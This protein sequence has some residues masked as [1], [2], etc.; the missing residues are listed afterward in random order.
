[1][2]ILYILLNDKIEIEEEN[3]E[4]FNKQFKKR[5]YRRYTIKYQ[6]KRF[7]FL[8]NQKQI[9]I[10]QYTDSGCG[11]HIWI[12]YELIGN[13][14]INDIYMATKK[15]AENITNAIKKTIFNVEGI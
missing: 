1:M 12:K 6:D 10:Q 13:C 2:N 3:I 14:G 15:E 11:Y 5:I 7:G 9:G 4:L 8:L